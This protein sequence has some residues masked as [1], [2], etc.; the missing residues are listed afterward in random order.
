[1]TYAMWILL[2]ITLLEDGGCLF[3]RLSG[4]LPSFRDG[5][6]MWYSQEQGSEVKGQQDQ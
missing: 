2:E 5:G 6:R 3:Q 1:M 4:D